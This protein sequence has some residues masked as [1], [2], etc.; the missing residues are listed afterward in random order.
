[1]ALFLLDSA[2]QLLWKAVRREAPTPPTAH[3]YGLAVRQ[4]VG[5]NHTAPVHTVEFSEVHHA[6]AAGKVAAEGLQRM[7]VP[8]HDRRGWFSR[9]VV[10][11]NEEF[12]GGAVHAIM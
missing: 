11:E 3:D 10:V 4:F 6:H 8:Q 2:L 5:I 1:M 7:C 9:R 12:L